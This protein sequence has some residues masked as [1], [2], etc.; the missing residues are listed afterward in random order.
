MFEE[1]KYIFYLLQRAIHGNPQD[2]Q[3]AYLSR[4][5]SLILSKNF[6]KYFNGDS[7]Q[8]RTPVKSHEVITKVGVVQHC[9]CN[10][11]VSLMSSLFLLNKAEINNVLHQQGKIQESRWLGDNVWFHHS[12]Y[13]QIYYFGFGGTLI[14][15]ALI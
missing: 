1:N 7:I 13:L 5:S 12:T 4:L 11:I 8:L 6:L 15:K 2:N 3:L 14:L 10:T 9:W